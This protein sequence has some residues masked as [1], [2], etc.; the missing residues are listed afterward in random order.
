MDELSLRDA[1]SPHIAARRRDDALHQAKPTIEGNAFRWCQRFA[2]LVEHRDRLAPITGKPGV[3]VSVD[4]RPEG[5]TLHPTARKPSGDRRQWLAVGV[6]LGGVTLPEGVL[7]LPAHRKVVADPKIAVAVEHRFAARAIAAAVEFKRQDRKSTRLNSSHL[8]ISYAVFCLLRL[9]PP[10]PLFPYTTLFRS[11]NPVV[12]G[13]SG[14]P[15]GSNLVALPCQ[16]AS[17]PCQPT[18]KL[19]PTQRL[20]SLS[21][22]ALPPA[23]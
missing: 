12:I 17:C 2:V 5:A 9:P 22:I 13:D 1:Q 8:G 11:A 6:K 18:V 21:N 23:R 14:L 4:R 3:V 10:S 20:P 15:L 19:S 7:P 16:K